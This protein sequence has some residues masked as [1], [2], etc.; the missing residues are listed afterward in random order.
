L[1]KNCL[2]ESVLDHQSAISPTW[3]LHKSITQLSTV[4]VLESMIQIILTKFMSA[5]FK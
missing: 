2:I 3:T 5:K 1:H 4:K